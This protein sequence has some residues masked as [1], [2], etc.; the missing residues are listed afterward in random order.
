[1]V[2]RP[3]ACSLAALLVA[4]AAAPV[5]AAPPADA[6]CVILFEGADGFRTVRVVVD[7][8]TNLTERQALFADLDADGDGAVDLLEQESLRA[9]SVLQWNTTG[10]LGIRGLSMAAGDGVSQWG[11]T[12]LGAKTWTQVGHTFHKQDHTTPALI[13]DPA[14]LE[15]QEVREFHFEHMRDPTIVLLSGGQDP[16]ATPTD[17][18][19]P[20]SSSSSSNTQVTTVEYVVVR[21]GP[22]WLVD[23]VNGWSYESEVAQDVDTP[24]LDLPA[25]DTKR[26][27]HL[28]FQAVAPVTGTGSPATVTETVTVQGDP[29]TTAGDRDRGSNGLTLAAAVAAVALAIAVRRRL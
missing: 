7:L 10:S 15:T 3:L 21:A 25:F 8:E 29:M 1:M 23:A 18:P 2:P 22:G 9:A 28:K 20:T 11:A 24:E 19:T 14:D 5:H 17:G 26:P 6:F 13:T 27:F 12:F 16:D 4:L